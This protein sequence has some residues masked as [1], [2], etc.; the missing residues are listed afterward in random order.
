MPVPT[1]RVGVPRRCRAARTRAHGRRRA[2]RARRRRRAAPPDRRGARPRSCTDERA[3]FRAFSTRLATICA[4]R[5]GSASAATASPGATSSAT[6]QPSAAGSK[7]ATAAPTTSRASIGCVSSENSRVSRRARSSRSATSRSSRRASDAM[8]AAGACAIGRR[9]DDAVGH[10]LRVALDRGE[11]RAEI[12]RDAE[13]ERP[14]V[15]PRGLELVGHRV[16]AARQ[17]PELVVGHLVERDAGRQ[18]AGRDLSGRGLHRRERPRQPAGE[19]GRHDRGDGEG[20]RARHEEPPAG[21]A[22]RTALDVLRHDQDGRPITDGRQRARDERGVARDTRLRVAGEQR[23]EVEI[24]GAEATREVGD[25]RGGLAPA[26]EE[27]VDA[28]ARPRR[29]GRRRPGCRR[30]CASWRRRAGTRG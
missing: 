2:R 18:V 30:R 25:V 24:V 5:S 10:G 22:E 19:E 8:T 20:D 16:D 21:L 15:A 29:P 23:V 1:L 26:A 28:F 4:S 7:P 3:Y 27:A 17:A 14:L 12:V 13:E 9:L 11:R 6:P